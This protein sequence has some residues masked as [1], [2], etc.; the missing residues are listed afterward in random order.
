MAANNN[1]LTFASTV[2]LKVTVDN[3]LAEVCKIPLV[4]FGTYQI[5]GQAAYD[6]TLCALKSGY[7]HIDTAVIYGNHVEVG[8]AINDFLNDKA[9]N[10][11]RQEVWVTTKIWPPKCEDDKG[12]HSADA[13]YELGVQALK[14]LQLDYVDLLLPHFPGCFM[15]WPKESD[16]HS[17]RRAAVWKGMERLHDDKKVRVLGVSNYEAHHIEELCRSADVHVR[18]AVNQYEYH[19]LLQKDDVRAAT[20]KYEIVNEAFSSLGQG[21]GDLLINK[22]IVGVAADCSTSAGRTVSTAQVLL[23]W[24]L[25]RDCIILP[26]SVTPSR[27]VENTKLYDFALTD[28]HMAAITALNDDKCLTWDPRQY[29]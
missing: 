3:K 8:K 6:A 29:Q 9:N 25:Q 13:C 2:E 18:P 7:R 5:T 1:A 12:E 14:E 4:G 19:P 10:C 16:N 21:K 15:K 26:K 20:A 22:V 23:R 28:A 17:K 24:A 11:T 27:I